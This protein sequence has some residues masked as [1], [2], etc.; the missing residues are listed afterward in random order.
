MR[1]LGR[2]RGPVRAGRQA[3]A[4]R[5]RG[6]SRSTTTCGPRRC[7]RLRAALPDAEQELAGPVLRG[8]ADAQGAGRGRGAA[9]GRRGD[10]PGAR[11]DR[12]VAAARP[13]RARGRP[14]HRRRRSWPR[15]T[16]RRLRDR[17]LRAQRRQPAP[18]GLRPG[19][20]AR[21]TR[22]WSTSAAPPRTATA[23][24]PPARTCVGRAAGRVPRRTTR[25]CRRPRQ[26]QWPRSGPGV[27]AESVDAAARDVDHRGR[28]RR[29][30]HPPHRARHRPGDPRGAVHRRRATTCRWSRAWRSSVEPGIYLPGRH[31]A[32]IEDIVVVTERAPS[33]STHQPRLSANS[34]NVVFVEQ[35]DAVTGGWCGS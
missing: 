16:R 19:D 24:T 4:A 18:R 14:G 15:G 28:L 13:D 20:R 12:R 9:G 10:R 22:S 3:A 29:G 27:T 2:D 34:E 26:A 11:A 23:P 1:R 35:L 30:V 17:R 31:G 5:G 6:G 33:G 32:R 8:A 21:A 25:C 7:S